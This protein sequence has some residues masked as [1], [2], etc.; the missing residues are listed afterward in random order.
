[1]NFQKDIIRVMSEDIN[2]KNTFY[3]CVTTIYL[4][5]LSFVF[6]VSLIGYYTYYLIVQL[7]KLIYR[8]YDE[9]TKPKSNLVTKELKKRKGKW[10]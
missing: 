9:N 1:M 4:S 3:Y 7:G 2:I 5:I 8:V 10:F 6:V